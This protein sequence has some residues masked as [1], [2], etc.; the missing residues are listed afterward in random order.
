MDLYVLNPGRNMAG[1]STHKNDASIRD[2]LT[3]PVG[4]KVDQHEETT[5]QEPLSADGDATGVVGDAVS[6]KR[7][8][9]ETL[10]GA[11]RTDIATLKQDSTADITSLPKGMTELGDRVSSLEQTGD[12]QAE[13]LDAH[14]REI[15]DLCDKN[16]ELSY[17]VEDL[18]NRSRRATIRIKGALLQAPGGN[19]EDYVHRLFYHIVQSSHLK[20]LCWIE[21]KG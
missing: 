8:F 21:P 6:V 15:L 17:H 11:L 16:A 19:L 13:E 3:K 10:F 7:A 14:R 2:L 4:K 5:S 20:I 9:L 12:T 18:H 1:R